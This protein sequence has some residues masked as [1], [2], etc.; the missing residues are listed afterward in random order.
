MIYPKPCATG[1]RPDIS[2]HVY[3]CGNDMLVKD[4]ESVCQSPDDF[5]ELLALGLA[6]G[7]FRQ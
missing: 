2:V 1:V 5:G 3:I 6:Y 4:L 7:S